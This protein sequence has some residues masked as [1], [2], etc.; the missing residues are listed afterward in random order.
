MT[1]L[2]LAGVLHFIY[3]HKNLL[4]TKIAE[5]MSATTTQRLVRLEA[6][7]AKIEAKQQKKLDDME[8]ARGMVGVALGIM[9]VIA[10]GIFG[11]SYLNFMMEG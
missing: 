9:V 2:L 8:A 10:A 4:S 7:Q 5:R 3:S 6:F 11:W 1:S